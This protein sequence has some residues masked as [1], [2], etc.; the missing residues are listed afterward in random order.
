MKGELFDGRIG[1]KCRSSGAVEEREENA[2]LFGED[3]D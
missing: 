2:R 3:A 1:M